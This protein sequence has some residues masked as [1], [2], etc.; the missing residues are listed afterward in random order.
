M[1][2]A[3]TTVSYLMVFVVVVGG[4]VFV[5]VGGACIW[6]G[7]GGGNARYMLWQLCLYSKTFLFLKQ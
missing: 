1:R 2:Y 4:L 5:C 6:G 7:G 3:L